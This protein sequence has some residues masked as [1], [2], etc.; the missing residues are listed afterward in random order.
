MIAA[1]VP[2]DQRAD[3]RPISFVLE[4]GGS[5][6]GQVTL[7]I[8]PEDLTR[9]EPS[10]VTVHQTLGRGV[11]GW[12]DH[13][14]EGLPSVSISGHTGWRAK[15]GARG[16]LLDGTESFEALNKLVAH[17]YHRAKQAAVD[18]GR[19]P[20]TVKLLFVD[21]LDKFAWSVVPTLFV[22]RRS[23]SRPLLIQYNISLQAV[24]TSVDSPGRFVPFFGTVASGLTALDAAIARLTGF[25]SNIQ[26]WVSG[27]VSFVDRALAPIGA[28]A[29]QFL[30]ASTQVFTAV[31]TAVR[32]VNNGI[33]STANSLI[34][35]A[36]DLAQAGSNAFRTIAALGSIPATLRAALG[37]VAG[38]YNEVLCILNNSLRQR[39][40]YESYEGLYGASNCSS[41]TG[42]RPASAYASTNVFELMRPELPPV[43]AD[44]LARSSIT[45][46]SRSD[47][48]LAPMAVP[49]VERHMVNVVE[50]LAA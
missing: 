6:S 22:L 29:K 16:E 20:A 32:S 34:G 41:T 46:L 3:I 5:I 10:R 24:D 21:L 49:D 27:A 43:T 15:P 4:S 17:D 13:F 42:G 30:S 11:Q 19:D 31:N 7:P 9:N 1:P 45:A 39:R 2:T 36:S 37:R 8:R 50:G 35:I 28:V 33:R 25:V 48:A 12:V 18:S 40:N 47:P 44:S 38:A 14:G 23:K 26:G